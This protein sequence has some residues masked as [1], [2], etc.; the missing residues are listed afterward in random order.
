MPSEAIGYVDIR[1]TLA[2][3]H[4]TVRERLRAILTDLAASD[5]DFRADI[6]F[7][8][9]RPVVGITKEEPIA[10][11]SAKAFHD[12][13]GRDPIWN[14]V[15]GATDGTFLSAWKK[16]PCLVNGPGPRHIPHQVDEYV[17]VDEIEECARVYVVSASRYLREAV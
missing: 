5:P 4:D 13:T 8:E 6:E 11:V 1:T 15:P 3:D 9:D 2:Q 12:V 17:A 10:R 16:I 14:G 7:I